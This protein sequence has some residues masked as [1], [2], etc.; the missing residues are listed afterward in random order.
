MDHF[1]FLASSFPISCAFLTALVAGGKW[2][3][4]FQIKRYISHPYN[5]AEK[6][7]IA[8]WVCAPLVDP[9]TRTQTLLLKLYI[10]FLEILTTVWQFEETRSWFSNACIWQQPVLK[11][12]LCTGLS[13]WEPSMLSR[14]KQ[15][16]SYNKK[17]R[18]LTLGKCTLAQRLER[19]SENRVS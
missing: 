18:Q 12:L 8:I 16:I 17:P 19:T 5:Y 4:C 9:Q 11:N 1:L 15:V 13:D 10:Y 6:T 3:P 2:F 7:E 14:R